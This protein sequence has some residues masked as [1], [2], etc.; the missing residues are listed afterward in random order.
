MIELKLCSI[1]HKDCLLWYLKKINSSV[2][3]RCVENK[4]GFFA[5]R[6]RD[7]VACAGTK[8]RQ[9]IRVIVSRCEID[10][11]NIKRAYQQFYGKSV[12]Q[13]IS[14][15]FSIIFIL[16]LNIVLQ[17]NISKDICLSG[18][19]IYLVVII[20]IQMLTI[21]YVLIAKELQL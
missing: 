21:M 15:W 5:Q 4:A 14:V 2:V 10:M 20:R 9:L 3:V 16:T 17:I 8:D 18:I 7:A 19:Y 12:E 1:S 11:Q 13:D 6:I